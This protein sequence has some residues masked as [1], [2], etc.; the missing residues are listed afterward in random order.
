VTSVVE[1]HKILVYVVSEEIDFGILLTFVGFK[2]SQFLMCVVHDL[3]PDI[4]TIAMSGR[5]NVD[6]ISISFP[7]L[8]ANST[9]D[10]PW[11]FI[12]SITGPL[13]YMAVQWVLCGSFPY[14]ILPRFFHVVLELMHAKVQS[15]FLGI[16]EGVIH[17]NRVYGLYNW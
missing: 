1:V 3:I 14:G 2:V 13:K 17:I 5:G 4:E 12:L 11:A 10:L 8:I 15:P 6:A 7:F 9:Q 16:L